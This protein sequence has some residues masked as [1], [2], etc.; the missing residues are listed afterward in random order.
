MH[1]RGK[2]CGVKSWRRW[3]CG[4][5]VGVDAKYEMMRDLGKKGRW[6]GEGFVS[7]LFNCPS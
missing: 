7:R 4:Y 2:T 3:D 6:K 5:V 1:V